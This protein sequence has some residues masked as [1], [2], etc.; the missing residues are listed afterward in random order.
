[1]VGFETTQE[2]FAFCQPKKVLI[3]LEKD[4]ISRLCD[5]LKRHLQ[6]KQKNRSS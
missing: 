5:I 3:S 6:E 4:L 1:M 2:V